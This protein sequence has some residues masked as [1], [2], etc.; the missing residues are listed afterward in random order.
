VEMSRIEPGVLAKHRVLP[1]VSEPAESRIARELAARVRG[2]VRFDDGSRALYATDASNYRQVPIGVVVPRDVDDVIAT[3]ELCRRY[4]LPVVSRGGGT[5]LAGQ[6]CNAA[7]LIDFSKYMHGVLELDAQQRI[8]RVE[9]GLILD[10]LRIAAEE[11]DLTFAPDP[12][13]H[14]HCTLGGMIGNNSC[15]VHSMMGGCTANNVHELDLLLYDGTRMQVGPTSDERYESIVS[16]GGRAA[17][18]YRRLR[19]LRDHYADAIRSGFPDIP[20]RVSGYNLPALLP[21]NGFDVA[22]ALCGSEGTLVTVLGA[23]VRLVPSPQC[24]VLLVLGYP[25]VYEAADHIEEVLASKPI[26]LEGVDDVLVDDMKRKRLHPERVELLPPGHGWLLAEF[27]AD[28]HDAARAQARDL[29]T[30]LQ[31][32][33]RAPTSKLCSDEEA[34]IIWKVRESG[35]G[36]TAR[37]PGQPDTWEGWEDSS[38]P[39]AKLGAYLRGLRSLLDSYDYRASLYGHFGQGCVH[40][41]IPFDL[42]TK[43]GIAKYRAFVEEAADLVVRQ[44]GSL[45]GEHG[46]GQSR[47]ELLPKMFGPELMRAFSEFKAIWDPHNKMNPG[48]I[49]RPYR[50]DE[51]LRFGPSYH[52]HHPETHF[53]FNDDR[54]S[55]AYATERCVGVGECRRTDGGTMCPSFMATREEMHSTRGRA[56]LLFETMRGD[57]LHAGFRS[58]AVRDALDLCLS[59]KGCKSDCPVNVDMATYKAE[60]LAH[61]YQGRLRPMSAY[62]FGLVRIW[63]RLAALA[64]RIVNWLTH[65]PGLSRVIKALGGIAQERTLPVFAPQTFRAWWRQ[66]P[67]QNAGKPEV[68]LWVDTFNDHWQPDI[69]RAAVDVLEHAGFQ[70]RLPERALCCGRPLYDYGML[71]RAK[72]QLRDVLEGL[73]PY[74]AAGTPVVGLEPSCVSVFR[75][76]LCGLFPDDPEAQ[77]LRSQTF[78]FGEFL[79]RHAPDWNPPRLPHKA[80]VHGHCHHKSVLDFERDHAVL[81]AVGLDYRVLD[82]GC[83]GMAGGFGYERDHYAVSIACGERTLLP[84]VRDAEDDTLVIADGFSCREQIVQRTARTPLHTAQVLALALANEQAERQT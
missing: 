39:P 40:T 36:A 48:K 82:S 65:A 52:P 20:R 81:R 45:S 76:E 33:Q 26:G 53:R 56:R 18:I 15:G 5:S 19:D 9:P 22:R 83:C 3:L 41:R 62:A 14:N 42:K 72:R 16:A 29:V 61:Y 32:S 1:V 71:T 30:R 21:E 80:I 69:P 34:K 74:I 24:R 73:R 49:V 13:T 51:N 68:V 66:R 54:G 12:S 37:V 6:G 43:P 46:D 23:K 27:G 84:E 64:P 25:N 7:V 79:T 75:D 63:A 60:F 55:F 44:G 10:H 2:E 50:I 11:F 70:V 38:V 57:A 17:E 77:R 28:S 78:M 47:A 4:A 59:C 58:H 67:P 8:A 31:Q 35:L